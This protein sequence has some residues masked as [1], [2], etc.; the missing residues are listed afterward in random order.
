MNR[1]EFGKMFVETDYQILTF[2]R[3]EL[4]YG[5]QLFMT[6]IKIVND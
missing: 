6:I 4:I 5:L 1:N 3:Q 2:V